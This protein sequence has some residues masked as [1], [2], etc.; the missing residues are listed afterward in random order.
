[1]LENGECSSARRS[2]AE[3]AVVG[4]RAAVVLAAGERV[5]QAVDRLEAAD[6]FVRRARAAVDDEHVRHRLDAEAVAQR[7]VGAV[8][9]VV[10]L[11]RIEVDLRARK[12]RVRIAPGGAPS[13][14]EWRVPAGACASAGRAAPGP[15]GM[16]GISVS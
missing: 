15:R 10:D 7:A 4:W 8:V 11:E 3:A 14:A 9:L 1:M 2:D 13:R 12:R 5:V 6:E 16:L